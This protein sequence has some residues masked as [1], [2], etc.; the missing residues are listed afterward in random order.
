MMKLRYQYNILSSVTFKL[1]LLN[2]ALYIILVS[3]FHI[4]FY[5]RNL[6]IRFN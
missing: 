3:Y 4:L 6:L 2:S 1:I 5:N